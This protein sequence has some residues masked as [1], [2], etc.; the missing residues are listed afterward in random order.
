MPSR[1][2]TNAARPSGVTVTSTEFSSPCA[3]VHPASGGAIDEFQQP[4]G[5]GTIEP[6]PGMSNSSTAS[7]PPYW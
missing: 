1:L 2:P 5:R 4:P 3:W 7:P 6:S